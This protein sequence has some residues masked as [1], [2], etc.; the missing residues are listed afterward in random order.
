MDI[1][2]HKD[3]FGT[4]RFVSRTNIKVGT[5]IQFTYDS[6]QK[7]AIVLNPDWEG[8]MHAISLKGIGAHD[9]RRLLNELKDNEN[10]TAEDLYK[11]Y[12]SSEYTKE[13]PYRTYINSKVSV[14]R[15]VYLKEEVKR[16]SEEEADNK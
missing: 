3:I 12:K 7:Y 4:R 16:K 14:L 11:I 8:K 2:A 9:L 5:I 15:E 1:D 6:E 13:R 10:N